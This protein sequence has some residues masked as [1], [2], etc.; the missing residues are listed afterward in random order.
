MSKTILVKGT[1]KYLSNKRRDSLPLDHPQYRPIQLPKKHKETEKQIDKF[2]AKQEYFKCKGEEDAGKNPKW[3]S[4]LPKYWSE[5][6]VTQSKLRGME[7]STVMQVPGM[8][9]S[10][11]L[12]AMMHREPKL[13][14]LCGYQIKYVER[15]GV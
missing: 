10:K 3:R 1:A 9:D 8:K 11:L 4:S 2:L 12:K 13:A 5:G 6:G 14:K 7:Y 15:S